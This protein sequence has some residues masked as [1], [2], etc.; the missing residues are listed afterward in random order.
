M[1]LTIKFYRNHHGEII[2]ASDK[3]GWAYA[4]LYDDVYNRPS[5][6]MTKEQAQQ[7]IEEKY[8]LYTTERKTRLQT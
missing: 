4:F 7:L 6:S 8:A 3:N 1:S 2:D 5:N